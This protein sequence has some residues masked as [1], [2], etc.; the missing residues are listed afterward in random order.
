MQQI[1]AIFAYHKILLD[2][3]ESFWSNEESINIGEKSHAGYL[4][5]GRVSARTFVNHRH[6]LYG[7]N[8]V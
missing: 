8:Y 4:N 3:K 5:V 1:M 2:R 6:L 7:T